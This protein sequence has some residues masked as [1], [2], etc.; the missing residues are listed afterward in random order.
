MGG[1]RELVMFSAIVAG[2]L[3][4]S[5]QNLIALAF[6]LPMWIVCIYFLRVMAKADPYM[7]KVYS[8]QLSYQS[9]YGA[10]STP[11]VRS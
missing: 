11:F 10:R 3:I 2:G 9:Y 6:G 7:S 8:R 1:E 4:I 5:A